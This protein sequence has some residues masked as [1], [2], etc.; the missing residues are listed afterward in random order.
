MLEKKYTLTCILRDT[1]IQVYRIFSVYYPASGIPNLITLKALVD[2]S[3]FNLDTK[4]IQDLLSGSKNEI[5]SKE[6]VEFRNTRTNIH[7]FKK[8]FKE[9]GIRVPIFSPTTTSSVRSRQDGIFRDVPTGYNYAEEN[10]PP[11]TD[12]TD[13]DYLQDNDDDNDDDDDD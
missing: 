6:F 9:I 13:Y 8:I 4:S 5:F 12:P 11:P 3:E 1:K 10:K 7:E 2:S